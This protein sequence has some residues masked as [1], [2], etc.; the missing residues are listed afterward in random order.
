MQ[1]QQQ[2]RE[3]EDAIEAARR[4]YNAVVREYNIRIEAFP[5]NVVATWFEFK[6]ADFFELGAP[7]TEKQP[8]KI[9]FS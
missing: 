6:K 1:L 4:T 9:S 8:V 5:S 2:L 7:E 3:L